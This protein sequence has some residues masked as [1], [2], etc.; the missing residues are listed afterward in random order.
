MKITCR[1]L[2]CTTAAT[3]VMGTLAPASVAFDDPLPSRNNA[4]AK[5]AILAFVKHTTEGS[6]P[7][8]VEPKD[9]VATFDRNG[10]LWTEH[11]AYGQARFALDRLGKMAPQH[12][13]WKETDPFDSVLTGDREAISRFSELE[14]GFVLRLAIPTATSKRSNGRRQGMEIV[15]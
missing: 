6:S 5:R 15:C 4:A 14:S 2:I 10:T 8:Y 3:A 9:R 12:P 13:D 11:P 7:K 1:D